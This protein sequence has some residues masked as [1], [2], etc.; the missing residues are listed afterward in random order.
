MYRRGR[1]SGH[2]IIQRGWLRC[3]EETVVL[4]AE[5]YKLADGST[6]SHF[7]AYQKFAKTLRV[8]GHVGLAISHNVEDRAIASSMNKVLKL[9]HASIEATMGGLSSGERARLNFLHWQVH[10]GCAAHD[11]HNSVKW[12]LSR[13]LSG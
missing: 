5:P 13:W 10:C 11:T 3:G 2:N 1:S 12:S 4:L 6:W 9:H 7:G 8:L